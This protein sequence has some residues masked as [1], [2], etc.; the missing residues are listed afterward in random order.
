MTGKEPSENY[1][2]AWYGLVLAFLLLQIVLFAW[3]TRY[4]G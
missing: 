4:F 1:W 3:L 2:K